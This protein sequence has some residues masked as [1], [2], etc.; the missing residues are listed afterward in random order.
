MLWLAKICLLVSYSIASV[1]KTAK[2]IINP[3]FIAIFFNKIY[4]AVFYHLL[5]IDYIKSKLFGLVLTYLRIVKTNGKDILYLY[6][7]FALKT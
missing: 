2:I 6:Y 4:T 3:I 1:F 7:W 5:V